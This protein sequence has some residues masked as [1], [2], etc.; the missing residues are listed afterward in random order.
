MASPRIRVL[1]L[2]HGLGRGGTEKTL[3]LF[4]ANLDRARFEVF[5][6]AFSDGERGRALRNAGIP[7]F[8]GSDLLEVLARVRPHLVHVHRA[9]W[10]E[11]RLLRTLRLARVP[12]VVETNVFGRHDPTPGAKIIDK[13]LFVS[14]FC[15]ER[16][17][18]DNGFALPHKKLD[19]LYNPVDTDFY[20]LAPYERD[21]SAPVFG[22][23]SRPDPGKWSGLALDILPLIK[24]RLPEF[25]CRIIGAIPEAYEFVRA[26]NLEH[27]VEFCEPVRD[28][29][30]VAEFFA[31]VNLLAHANDA[32]ESFGLAI[33]E[34]MAA[35]LPVV[36]H[37]AR[38]NRDNAQLELVE[39]GVTGFVA[40]SAASYADAVIRLLSR[41]KEA[42][43]MGRAGREKAQ[44]LFRLGNLVRKLENIYLEIVSDRHHA[45]NRHT[46]PGAPLQRI[47]QG[48]P[49]L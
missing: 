24:S 5:V 17:A 35:G 8:A 37:P 34:A 14:R 21:W 47:H 15:L 10:P 39:H 31:G 25:K 6:F 20:G 1:H 16:Y 41:P 43:T 28:E 13:H 49:A 26:K 22:R 45:A 46:D 32:G 4:A 12:H 29:S 42:E 3:Q 2:A 44:R 36:T 40:E 7:V 48:G 23:L 19:F 33:A 11:P 27:N 38:G 30:A 18:R 9:G